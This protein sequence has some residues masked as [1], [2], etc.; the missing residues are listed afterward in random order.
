MTTDNETLGID[1]KNTFNTDHDLD[2]ASVFGE[3]DVLISGRMKV[4]EDLYKKINN[5]E[6]LTEEERESYKKRVFKLFA[7]SVLGSQYTSELC[8]NSSFSAE[9]LQYGSEES[10]EVL[11]NEL[12]H[13]FATIRHHFALIFEGLDKKD[14]EKIKRAC[15]DFK[16]NSLNAFMQDIRRNVNCTIRFE[17]GSKK[18]LFKFLNFASGE[19]MKN[20]SPEIVKDKFIQAFR[21]QGLDDDAIANIMM[22]FTQKSLYA[23]HVNTGALVI[24]E[25]PGHIYSFSRSDSIFIDRDIKKIEITSVADIGLRDTNNPE[26]LNPAFFTIASYTIPM[27]SDNSLTSNK[28]CNEIFENS[29]GYQVIPT[30]S[31]VYLIKNGNYKLPDLPPAVIPKQLDL[32]TLDRYLPPLGR[33][34]FSIEEI[35]QAFKDVFDLQRGG[36]GTLGVEGRLKNII[37]KE[38]QQ[39]GKIPVKSLEGME[40]T[41]HNINSLIDSLAKEQK[42]SLEGTD[43]EKIK[44]DSVKIVELKARLNKINPK[45]KFKI[46]LELPKFNR[47][48][49]VV[50]FWKKVK[51]FFSTI[52]AAKEI[53]E[54]INLE[55]QRTKAE[56]QNAIR[57]MFTYKKNTHLR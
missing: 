24:K 47:F 44:R 45:A 25:N 55:K 16:E 38:R 6:D 10:Q 32:D 13:N 21:S 39:E 49:Q 12:D 27:K 3:L 43:K 48:N 35:T 7:E 52:N 46:N 37:N 56:A 11:K 26:G 22:N 50:E 14:N 15:K 31:E 4:I 1:L 28:T 42:G 57:P 51:Q 19:E 36:A 20:A 18:E 33:E 9:T 54:A 5:G 30:G 29:L 41:P 34:Y 17:D 8:T 53:G 23:A 40:I 2:T